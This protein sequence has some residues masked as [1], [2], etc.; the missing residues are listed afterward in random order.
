MLVSNKSMLATASE[1]ISKLVPTL[2][3]LLC[4]CCCC[5]AYGCVLKRVFIM[6]EYVA[7]YGFG[8]KSRLCFLKFGQ[9]PTKWLRDS[10]TERLYDRVDLFWD[11]KLTANCVKNDFSSIASFWFNIVACCCLMAESINNGPL[12]YLPPF[13][14]T[15]F[16]P[17]QILVSGGY[18]FFTKFF[19][20]GFSQVFCN[21]A[22]RPNFVFGPHNCTSSA[23]LL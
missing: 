6:Y 20:S 18:I 22:F 11:Y 23:L 13:Q 7:E 9:K 17:E 14:T 3:T 4:C 15:N 19:S 8:L 1:S 10:A 12:L 21:Q 16:N 2:Y 5:L